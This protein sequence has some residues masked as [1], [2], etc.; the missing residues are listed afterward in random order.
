MGDVTPA[1]EAGQGTYP[2]VLGYRDYRDYWD[3]G[4]LNAIIAGC[5]GSVLARWRDGFIKRAEFH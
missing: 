4:K 1:A 3:F 2:W 5:S